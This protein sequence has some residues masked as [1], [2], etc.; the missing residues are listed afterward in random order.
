[1]LSRR[2]PDKPSDETGHLGTH[3]DTRI[4]R[5]LLIGGKT[6]AGKLSLTSHIY[7]SNFAFSFSCD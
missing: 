5:L 7:V 3:Q 2:R 1:M 6:A 4:L